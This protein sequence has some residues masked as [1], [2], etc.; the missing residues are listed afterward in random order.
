MMISPEAKFSFLGGH[1]VDFQEQIVTTSHVS[2]QMLMGGWMKWNLKSKLA[3]DLESMMCTGLLDGKSVLEIQM[4]HPA[5]QIFNLTNFLNNV[6]HLQV[7]AGLES[8]ATVTFSSPQVLPSHSPLPSFV[9]AHPCLESQAM[10]PLH[11]PCSSLLLM[12]T[13][14]PSSA[15]MATCCWAPFLSEWSSQA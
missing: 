1:R 13:V 4:E 8:A 15:S 11:D 12:V 14:D 3:Q 10:Q 2:F 6:S 9:Q 7:K 5:Y